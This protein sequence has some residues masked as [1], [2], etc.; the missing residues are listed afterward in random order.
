M[1][2]LM[3]SNIYEA[4]G[5][6]L[7]AGTCLPAMQPGAFERLKKRAD[8]CFSLCLEQTHINMAITK[9]AGVLY[10]GQVKCLMF[11][12]VDESPHC[13]QMHYIQNELRQMGMLETIAVENYVAV[14]D[15]PIL[16]TPEG[17]LRSKKLSSSDGA[18][19]L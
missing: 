15:R 9:L 14:D 8:T 7:I 2:E 4:K 19:I 11:A 6:V 3:T 17:I 16:L 10:T 18:Q 12:T 13:V 5:V 1:K